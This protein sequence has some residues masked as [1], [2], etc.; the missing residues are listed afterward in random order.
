MKMFLALALLATSAFAV[1]VKVSEREVS[2]FYPNADAHFAV[3]RLMGTAWVEVQHYDQL[4]GR[5]RTLPKTY[6]EK[7]EGLSFDQATSKIVLTYEGQLFECA[8]V[9]KK[10]Y[11]TVIRP[12]NC[13]LKVSKVTRTVDTG[14]RNSKRSF[15][16]VNLVTK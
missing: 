6:R 13:E 4:T 15:H 3:D 2:Y 8:D 9:V 7:V 5:D 12:T 1:E 10:W 14:R 16:Q 11:G